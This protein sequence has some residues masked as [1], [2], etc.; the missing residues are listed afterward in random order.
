MQQLKPGEWISSVRVG[1]RDEHAQWRERRSKEAGEWQPQRSGPDQ[2]ARGS[3]AGAAERPPQVPGAG[4]LNAQAGV[5][6]EGEAGQ[7]RQAWLSGA[8][9]G[10][11]VPPTPAGALLPCGGVLR[12]GVKS[13]VSLLKPQPRKHI[14]IPCI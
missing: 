7:E 5:G 1:V 8:R 13:C 10:L 2:R 4:C 12:S 9:R 11:R 3:R 14:V 6:Q